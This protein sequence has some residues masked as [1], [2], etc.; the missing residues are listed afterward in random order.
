MEK[1]REIPEFDQRGFLS[2]M[3]LGGKKKVDALMELL[4][5]SAP[6]RITELK[7]AK[8]LAEAKAAV[9]ALKMSAGNLGLARLEDYC[10]QILESKT[11]PL[12]GG[13]IH[14]VELAYAHG[15]KALQ[16]QRD[17]I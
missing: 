9:Q 17:R 4:G 6:V 1:N 11:W 10:D 14:H 16:A 3:K 15:H 13:M 5:Q 12:P 2:L 7:A 8:S